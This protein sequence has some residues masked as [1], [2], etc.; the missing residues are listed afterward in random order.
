MTQKKFKRRVKRRVV[1]RETGI[2]WPRTSGSLGR[3]FNREKKK[4]EIAPQE[5]V[6]R[7]GNFVLLPDFESKRFHSGKGKKRPPVRPRQKDDGERRYNGKS[8][9]WGTWKKPTT[10]AVGVSRP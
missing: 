7:E 1:L 5:K 3:W 6:S 9:K 2:R 10:L 4:K 8:L